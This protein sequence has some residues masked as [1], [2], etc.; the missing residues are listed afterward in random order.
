MSCSGTY[1][2]Q[3]C[4]CNG[5]NCICNTNCTGGFY[6]PG[7][8]GT[9]IFTDTPLNT[10][11][12]VRTV[13]INQLRQEIENERAWRLAKYGTAPWTYSFA[14]LQT[15]TDNISGLYWTQL[16]DALN[17]IPG[18]TAIS[19]TYTIAELVSATKLSLLRTQVSTMRADCVCNSDCNS[20][21]SCS[22]Y[23]DCGCH[24]DCG[25]NYSDRE[26]KEEITYI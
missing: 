6:A 7:V 16:R 17:N 8:R 2:N 12:N 18:Y 22:C 14:T 11:F 1:C 23:N 20:F 10:S 5:G 19:D 13:H 26:L 9:I 21:S 25:C 3:N 15:T 4:T 24:N